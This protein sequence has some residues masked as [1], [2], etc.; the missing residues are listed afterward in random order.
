M[1]PPDPDDAEHVAT[2]LS[3]W[4]TLHTD[5]LGH[6]FAELF[7]VSFALFCSLFALLSVALSSRFAPLASLRLHCAV[8]MFSCMFECA[9]CLFCV[10]CVLEKSG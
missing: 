6:S 10:W 3:G 8:C 1:R 7:A 5:L 2:L 4:V 9:D